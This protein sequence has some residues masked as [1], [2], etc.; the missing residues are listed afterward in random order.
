VKKEKF[1]K[2]LP[3]SKNFIMKKE[4]VRR[5]KKEKFR[6]EGFVIAIILT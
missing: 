5:G 3:D 4:R 6:V 1:V 2:R